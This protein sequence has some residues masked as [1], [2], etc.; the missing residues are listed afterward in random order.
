MS[1]PPQYLDHGFG[2][3]NPSHLF[4][5]T[6]SLPA[7]AAADRSGGV[8]AP[9]FTVQALSKAFGPVGDAA[10]ITAGSFDARKSLPTAKLLGALDLKDLIAAA[11]PWRI[12]PR[13]T[14]RRCVT[15][16]RISCGRA[17][18]TRESGCRA[19][20][21]APGGG[22]G[23]PA[24]RRRDPLRLEAGH[25]K[26]VRRHLPLDLTLDRGAELALS[27]TG[28]APVGAPDAATSRID[29]GWT[30]SR[31]CSPR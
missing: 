29:G 14:R 9:S 24:G 28:R 10:G 5:S 8:A 3:G 19:G 4:G 23:R 27:V 21:G 25:P 17:W 12:R 22:R 11:V 13:S 1:Y 2:P 30:A 31:W 7:A 18:T 16:P 20:A 15:S 6:G 26:P